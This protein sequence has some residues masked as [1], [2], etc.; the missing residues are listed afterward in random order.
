MEIV[1]KEPT[2]LAILFNFYASSVRFFLIMVIPNASLYTTGTNGLLSK[3]FF[4]IFFSLCSDGS[5]LNTSRRGL[6][7]WE[8]LIDSEKRVDVNNYGDK[9]LD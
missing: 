7:F 5:N 4:V 1:L 8:K 9:W 6:N 3:V 2:F